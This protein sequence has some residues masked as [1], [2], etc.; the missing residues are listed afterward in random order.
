MIAAYL[1]YNRISVGVFM[2]TSG[3]VKAGLSIV[4][5]LHFFDQVILP[6]NWFLT[7]GPTWL[8]SEVFMRVF[9]M[10]VPAIICGIFLFRRRRFRS[11]LVEA[12][13][14]GVI[15][16]ALYNLVNVGLFNQGSWYYGASIF[17]A[18]FVIALWLD[19]AA[20]TL[21]PLA[22]GEA[23][24]RPWAAAAAGIVFVSLCFNIYVHHLIASDTA[25]GQGRQSIF[26]QRETLRAM[27]R[28]AG[29]DRFIEFDDGELS[30]VTGMPA[31]SGLGLVLDPEAGRAMA[32]EHFFDLATRRHYSLIMAAGIYRTTI[33]SVVESNRRGDTSSLD[34]I[35]AHESFSLPDRSCVLR[36]RVRSR[37][38]SHHTKTLEAERH[39]IPN[40]LA[41]FASQYF[42][43]LHAFGRSR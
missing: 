42:M 33:D 40:V 7:R 31:L 2:P 17:V 25:Q 12:L 34:L 24:F 22:S 3:S 30:Y 1:V 4:G 5:N 8:F 43:Q 11:D 35:S 26:D 21:R 20:L 36:S 28:H 10:I 18:N 37:T 41:Q 13:C 32:D 27:V 14:F 9:Q 19:R 23:G 6:K 29:S 15:L 38:L 39:R 16:K